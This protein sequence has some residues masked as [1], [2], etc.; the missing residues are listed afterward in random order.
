MRL[1]EID[2]VKLTLVQEPFD[3]P[4]FVFELKHDGFRALAYTSD[5]RCELVSRRR[6]SGISRTGTFKRSRQQ[7][8]HRD[9][10]GCANVDMAI[11]DQR[12]DEFVVR[13]QV[14]GVGRLV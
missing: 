10:I 3:H 7:S 1:P 11:G 14:A 12:G 8:E 4:D 5:G 13:E 9:A 6:A 2:P